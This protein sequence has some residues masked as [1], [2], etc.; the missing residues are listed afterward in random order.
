MSEKPFDENMA[1]RRKVGELKKDGHYSYVS[2]VVHTSIIEKSWIDAKFS[3]G[4]K[5]NKWVAIPDFV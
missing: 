4:L 2:F 5:H 1:E 3:Q